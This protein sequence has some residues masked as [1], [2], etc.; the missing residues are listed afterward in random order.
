MIEHKAFSQ[1]CS[2]GIWSHKR[3]YVVPDESMDF[4]ASRVVSG[5]GGVPSNAE[6]LT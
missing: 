1:E 4:A 3:I 2:S 5:M 6:L